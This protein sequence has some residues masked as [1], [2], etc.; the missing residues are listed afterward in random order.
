MLSFVNIQRVSQINKRSFIVTSNDISGPLLSSDGLGSCVT[1]L[2]D[3]RSRRHPWSASSA[4]A[5]ARAA[6]VLP[7]CSPAPGTLSPVPALV[8]P[9]NAVGTAHTHREWRRIHYNPTTLPYLEPSA[10]HTLSDLPFLTRF[11]D[12]VWIHSYELRVL[13]ESLF[14]V[15][16][17][18]QRPCGAA[19]WC[20]V[21]GSGRSLGKG[22]CLSAKCPSSCVDY[23]WV[24]FQTLMDV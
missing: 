13:K 7:P 3:T 20:T 22:S 5:L 9:G 4:P 16:C 10:Y 12:L 24:P 2:L 6:A 17:E 14:R 11:F 8:A 18:V 23:I 15:K 19:Q 1:N 21:T